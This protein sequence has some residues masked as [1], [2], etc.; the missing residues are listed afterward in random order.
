MIAI[1][2]AKNFEDDAVR[3]LLK[4]NGNI[5]M[6]N[7]GKTIG[8][9]RGVPKNGCEA[10]HEVVL[11]KGYGELETEN[12]VNDIINHYPN[13]D[14]IVFIGCA[15]GVP[16]HDENNIKQ[17]NTRLGDVVVS[18]SVL[19]ISHVKSNPD[20][21]FTPRG[22][23]IGASR[24]LLNIAE[25]ITLFLNSEQ[26]EW[27]EIIN[28]LI[29]QYEPWCQELNKRIP[30]IKIGNIGSS[31]MNVNDEIIRDYWFN[32]KYDIICFE[33]EGSAIATIAALRDKHFI[34]IRGISDMAAGER[35]GDDL[36]QPLA[37]R[38][39]AAFLRVLLEKTETDGG[40][41]INQTPKVPP[42]FTGRNKELEETKKE[43][44]IKVTSPICLLG[45][46]GIGKTT[47]A[48]KL[49]HDTDIESKFSDGVLWAKLGKDYNQ[50]E[51]VLR[52]WSDALN[53]STEKLG[54]K[55]ISELIR[56]KIGNRYMLLVVDDIWEVKDAAYF[57]EACGCNCRL[58]FTTRSPKIAQFISPDVKIIKLN[59]LTE[60][61]GI[62]L[63]EQIA[64]EAVK[65]ER[66]AASELVKEVRSLPVLLNVMGQYIALRARGKEREI[67]HR[68][69]D[70][71]KEAEARFL[72]MENA[73]GSASASIFISYNALDSHAQNTFRAVSHFRPNPNDFSEEV[74]LA[75][76]G[77]KEE[78]LQRLVQAGLIEKD[79]KTY[80]MHAVIAAYGRSISLKEEEDEY[81]LRATEF[82]SKRLKEY[83]E[84]HNYDRQYLYEKPEWQR[85]EIEWLYHQGKRGDRVSANL[86]FANLYFGGFWWWGV[87][88]ESPFC[89]RLLEM[90]GT[91]NRHEDRE[92]LANLWQFQRSYP[93][94]HSYPDGYN[95]QHTENWKLVKSALEEIRKLGKLEQEKSEL[96]Q[97]NRHVRALTNMFLAESYHYID[98]NY[99]EAVRLVIEA[100]KL[101][102]EADTD[103]D[104]WNVPWTLWYL[105]DLYLERKGPGDFENALTSCRK[106][107]KMAEEANETEPDKRDNEVISNCYRVIADVFWKQDEYKLAFQSY[108]YAAYFAYLFQRYPHPP[109]SYT[110][111]FFKE[112]RDRTQ[113]RLNE[114]WHKN[115]DSVAESYN[116][117]VSFWKPYWDL[118]EKPSPDFQSLDMSGESFK[119]LTDLV[120]P[121]IPTAEDLGKQETEY[122]KCVEKVSEKIA[123]PKDS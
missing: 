89:K 94:H 100:K 119:K 56:Y 15:A 85:I 12:N 32:S 7:W 83:E 18:R 25:P 74:A 72:Q 121:P 92:W 106:S 38:V 39:A 1:F 52:L 11:S 58:L 107:I 78:Q 79:D 45:I 27:K 6:D 49:A 2:T 96:G 57:I 86:N 19:D 95:E 20:H 13:V 70:E 93:H 16:A 24:Y 14:K 4:L 50:I 61:D 40:G 103:D 76:S 97:L 65:A 59:D 104:N 116:Y 114:L 108:A 118:L 90:W 55:K 88:W 43:L 51:D 22:E 21:T 9:I 30:E 41:Y 73:E 80:T 47:I 36:W 8:R 120:L 112:M 67:I 28:S 31:N 46:P 123:V 102:E 99:E 44:L 10:Y 54:A 53:I 113:S 101:F 82:Y 109:D 37:S 62:K 63:L 35:S 34:L 111:N 60:E 26:A 17:G 71:L 75:A 48:K 122:V 3:S 105:G 91:Q 29:K 66:S 68:T 42:N 117:L 98:K 84:L 110:I 5:A 33:M 23:P 77:E 87:Y 69:V 115:K 81:H 64:P